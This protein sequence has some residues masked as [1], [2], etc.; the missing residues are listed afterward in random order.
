ML[1]TRISRRA[2]L[3]GAT[4]LAAWLSSPARAFLQAAGA[5]RTPSFV[6]DLIE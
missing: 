1:D 6:N 4:A 2:A 3:M 5:A